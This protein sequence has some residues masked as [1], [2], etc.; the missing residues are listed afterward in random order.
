M[1]EGLKVNN[2]SITLS[3]S[4]N[5]YKGSFCPKFQFNTMTLG[6]FQWLRMWFIH[7]VQNLK[8]VDISF[9]NDGCPLVCW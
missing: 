4:N 9:N 5:V 1:V 8:L 3:I 2:V 7:F 6:H